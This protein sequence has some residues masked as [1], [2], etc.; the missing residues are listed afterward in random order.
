[1][2][3]TVLYFASCKDVVG[4]AEET[5]EL[6]PG[7]NA[8]DL[9]EVLIRTHPDL[10][11]L[12]PA[13]AVS[14]NQEYA[15]REASLADGDEVALIPPVSGGQSLPAET[16]AMVERPIS[17]DEVAQIV[18]RDSSG[19]VAAFG[20]VVREETEGRRVL[21]LEYEAYPSMAERKMTQIGGEIGAKW[22][23][24]AVAILHRV[25]H[26]E[27]GEM[28]VAIAVAAPHR[29]EALEACSYAIERLKEIVPIWKKEVFEDGEV[30]VGH[31]SSSVGR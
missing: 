23:V 14:V 25:G 13:L 6:E 20:G 5:V 1:M 18:R 10:K 12:E 4:A 2:K 24:D 15:A 21:Y 30:W 31:H 17:L 28:S 3:V 27:V 29:R 11:G 7:A 19:A 26:L 16:Y 8:Q 9:L 22:A